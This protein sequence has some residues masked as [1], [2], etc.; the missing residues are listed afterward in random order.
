MKRLTLPADKGIMSHPSVRRRLNFAKICFWL[1]GFSLLAGV[2][3]RLYAADEPQ[4]FGYPEALAAAIHKVEPVY[5]EAARPLKIESRV[6]IDAYVETDGSVY[7]TIIVVGDLKLVDA[8]A[9]A[10]RQWKF[11]S[12]EE[13][14]HPIRAIAR[15]VFQMKPPVATRASR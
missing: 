8:A 2:S 13:N 12:F 15:L 11:K 1:L 5:P 3:P 9:E 10:A 14:G 6:E 7:S 4:R